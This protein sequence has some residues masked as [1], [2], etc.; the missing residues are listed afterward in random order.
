M[1]GLHGNAGPVGQRPG[2]V[3]IVFGTMGNR[4][5]QIRN[6]L[7]PPQPDGM[8]DSGG[9]VEPVDRRPPPQH[10]I[11][12]RVQRSLMFRARTDDPGKG[13]RSVKAEAGLR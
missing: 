7:P 10:E 6:C 5:S 4:R 12:R 8:D 3:L 9:L 1:A 11:K 13:L 2:F